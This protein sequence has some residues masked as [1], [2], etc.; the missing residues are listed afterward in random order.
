[1]SFS[2]KGSLKSSEKSLQHILFGGVLILF[3]VL[4]CFKNRSFWGWWKE[5]VLE[6]TAGLFQSPLEPMGCLYSVPV[7]SLKL[8]GIGAV[9]R[10]LSVFSAS[11]W[12][13]VEQL[14]PYHAHK[15]E[16][17]KINKGKRFQQAVDAV[18]EFLR[19]AKGKDQVRD[20]HLGGCF[21]PVPSQSFL[22]KSDRLNVTSTQSA[23]LIKCQW[24]ESHFT[25]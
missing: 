11:A 1:M 18:E 25:S 12:I 24:R 19:R 6:R 15:E 4:T 9:D 3:V 20:T 7:K 13:K 5:H 22:H 23:I 10:N 14:K 21:I 17:I 16:M 2:M 8:A